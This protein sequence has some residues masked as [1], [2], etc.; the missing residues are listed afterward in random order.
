MGTCT[1]HT[2]TR[3][4]RRVMHFRARARSVCNMKQC[5]TNSATRR[6]PSNKH[7][8]NRI[9][10]RVHSLA[11]TCSDGIRAPAAHCISFNTQAATHTIPQTISH[12]AEPGAEPTGNCCKQSP[13]LNPILCIDDCNCAHILFCTIFTGFFRCAAS[14]IDVQPQLC[15]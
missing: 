2:H 11:H 8:Q 5:S 6:P 13:R 14:Q 10:T 12:S 3:S 15:V 7:T 4:A 1:A 9:V